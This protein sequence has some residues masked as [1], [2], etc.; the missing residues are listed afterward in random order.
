MTEPATPHVMM[1][2]EASNLL[3]LFL[4]GELDPRQTRAVALHATRCPTCESRLRQL[5]R[6]QDLISENISAQVDEINFSEFW[7]AVG[8]RLG[9]VRM[10]SWNRLRTWWSDGDA[11]A[12]HLPIFAAAAAA[13][14]AFLFL[15]RAPQRPPEADPAQVAAVDN[16]ASIDSLDTDFDTVAVLTDPETRT[17]VLWVGND[18]PVSGDER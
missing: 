5:E 18:G 8:R 7:P 15:T 17:T 9:T 2:G 3:S 14:L 4:D 10:S 11:W 12:V 1:C 13:V 16:T 6:L